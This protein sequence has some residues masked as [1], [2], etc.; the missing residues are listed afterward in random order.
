MGRKAPRKRLACRVMCRPNGCRCTR[1]FLGAP[2]TPRFGVGEAT[3]Q[4][5]GRKMRR[6]N[7]EVCVLEIVR[8]GMEESESAKKQENTGI[9]PASAC[10]EQSD[11]I[12]CPG[13]GAARASAKRCTADPGPPRTGTVPGLQ[14]TTSCCAAPGTRERDAFWRNE[15]N[16]VL[17][18]RSQMGA[19]FHR[20]KGMTNGPS[21]SCVP[22]AMQRERQRSG[23]SLIRDRYGLERSRVCSA[24]LRAA[25]RPGHESGR[26]PGRRWLWTGRSTNL[27]VY[28]M[29]A[30]A[31]SLF[32][33][34]IYN[35]FCNSHVSGRRGP[36][37]LPKMC[38]PI[39]HPD[40]APSVVI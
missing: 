17:A 32:R 12:A 25:L 1:T 28:E 20:E 26:R 29:T 10:R 19:K 33:V 38:R 18:K 15:P 35:D 31:I 7:A 5:P 27:R 21:V 30:G 22:D 34:V 37:L 11:A 9:G 23:A 3:M 39:C 2:P 8:P 16:V 36:N 6:G 40:V 24:P 13:R 4:N 14:R